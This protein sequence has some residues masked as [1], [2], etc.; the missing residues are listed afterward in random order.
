MWAYYAKS[1]ILAGTLALGENFLNRHALEFFGNNKLGQF[2]SGSP[3]PNYLGL[4]VTYGLVVLVNVVGLPYY[5]S[6]LGDLVDEGRRKYGVKLP[7][8]YAP[9]DSENEFK[10]NSLQRIHGNALENLPGLVL[11]SLISGISHPISTATMGLI[12]I[13]S[14]EQWCA[15][16]VAEGPQ[17][18]YKQPFAAEHWTA[19][20][21]VMLLAIESGVKMMRLL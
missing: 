13:A 16:Y 8:L 20:L 14:R 18:R 7:H 2:L 10:F 4:P 9:G 1:G 17:G 12:W 19:L 11:M 6:S 15:G 21:G 3:N 5:V